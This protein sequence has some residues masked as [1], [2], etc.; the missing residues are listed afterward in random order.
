MQVAQPVGQR[1]V[2]RLQA[3]P[4]VQ[5]TQRH[6]GFEL[7]HRFVQGQGEPVK[8]QPLWR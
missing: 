7:S 1:L 4:V 5:L 8:E 3:A 6:R 2:P